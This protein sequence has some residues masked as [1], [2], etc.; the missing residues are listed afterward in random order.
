MESFH[1]THLSDNIEYGS[2]K[3]KQVVQKTPVQRQQKASWHA[4]V[5][6]LVGPVPGKR[7]KQQRKEG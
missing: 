7:Q 3:K 4:G 5:M 2:I 1:A 6:T